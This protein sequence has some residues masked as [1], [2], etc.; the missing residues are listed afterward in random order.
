MLPLNHFVMAFSLKDP[1]S[2]Q[3]WKDSSSMAKHF[4][5][6]V[7]RKMEVLWETSKGVC[8]CGGQK[9]ATVAGQPQTKLSW[10]GLVRQL[11]WPDREI[12]AR[13]V[14][15]LSKSHVFPLSIPDRLVHRFERPDICPRGH[16]VHL[17][18]TEQDFSLEKQ[19]EKLCQTPFHT[20]L[21][22]NQHISML[23]LGTSSA[24]SP[25]P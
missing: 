10:T 5:F 17:C 4:Y 2:I 23:N 1:S 11:M 9:L 15:N 22:T 13:A 21:T 14:C 7:K 20:F 24:S 6:T 19:D 3:T 25:L 8:V 16:S 12:Q 18:F